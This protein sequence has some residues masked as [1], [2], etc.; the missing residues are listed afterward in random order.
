MS[1]WAVI[2]LPPVAIG[3]GLLPI[4]TRTLDVSLASVA[5][6]VWHAGARL[7]GPNDPGPVPAS[8]R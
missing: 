2:P 6:S 1:G 5:P 3:E 4:L 8:S 7:C